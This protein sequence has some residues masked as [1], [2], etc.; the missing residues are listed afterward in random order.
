MTVTSEVTPARSR[1][2]SSDSEAWTSNTIPLR[3]WLWKPL[4]VAVTV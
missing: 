1:V 3:S 4:I 2:K